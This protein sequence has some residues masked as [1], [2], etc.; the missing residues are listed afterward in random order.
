[1]WFT[2]T[3]TK[4]DYTGSSGSADTTI[5]LRGLAWLQKGQLHSRGDELEN[6][7]E[8]APDGAPAHLE[9]GPGLA[10]GVHQEVLEHSHLLEG[11]G[12]VCDIS[13]DSE[14]LLSGGY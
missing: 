13:S 9:P 14:V 1:M 6:R 8:E 12:L 10:A 7:E 2:Y 3:P 5:I 4:A 11:A